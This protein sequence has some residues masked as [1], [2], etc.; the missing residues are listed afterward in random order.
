MFD[1][2]LL[3]NRA[4][5]MARNQSFGEM[6]SSFVDAFIS[7]DWS[8]TQQVVSLSKYAHMTFV[9]YRLHQCSFMPHQLYGDTQTTVKNTIFCLAKQQLLDGT[10]P[11]YLYDTGDDKLEELFGNVRMQQIHSSRLVAGKGRCSIEDYRNWEIQR[12]VR[13]RRRWE[14]KMDHEGRIEGTVGM[15]WSCFPRSRVRSSEDWAD[16]A[17]CMKYSY[18]N[19]TAV[20]SWRRK[21]TIVMA[22]HLTS[23][24][25]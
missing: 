5:R 19:S 6:L 17:E 21:C 23:C 11:F 9:F 10:Q 20:P 22:E 7:P 24:R 16:T 2:R 13:R 18:S 15:Y 14:R 1:R 12:R 3:A 25:P 4:T 8:L